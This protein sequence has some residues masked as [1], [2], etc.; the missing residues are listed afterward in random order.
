MSEVAEKPLK[1]LDRVKLSDK[2]NG[3]SRTKD[4]REGIVTFIDGDLCRVLWDGL[5]TPQ[6]YHQSFI[7]HA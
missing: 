6:Q 7:T 2:W 4:G 5:R 3:D 1:R